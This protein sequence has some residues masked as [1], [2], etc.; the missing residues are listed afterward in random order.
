MVDSIKHSP[1]PPDLPLCS[2]VG[3][4]DLLFYLFSFGGRFSSSEANFGRAATAI[5]GV[6]AELDDGA[7]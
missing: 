6:H 2:F 7:A 4:Q 5:V 3:V 1:T